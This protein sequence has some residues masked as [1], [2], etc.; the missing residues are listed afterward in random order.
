V[1]DMALL[2]QC[3]PHVSPQTM[4]AII[5]T[6]SGFNPLALHVNGSL[7]LSS[8]PHTAAEAAAWAKWL[9]GQGYSVDLGLM[10]VN[11]NN[12]GRLGMTEADAFDPCQN[13]QAGARILTENYAK[14]A[15]T[16]GLGTN[17]LLQAISAYNTGNFRD[18]FRNGYVARVVANSVPSRAVPVRDIQPEDRGQ[19]PACW[20]DSC[21]TVNAH[22]VAAWAV[23]IGGSVITGFTAY[24]LGVH[25]R[26]WEGIRARVPVLHGILAQAFR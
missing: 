12:L 23:A 22:K 19:I 24:F 5:R 25:R 20:L 11:S 26:A 16:G 10:Q 17:A 8:A 2:H 3:A 14:A 1:L 15:Q 9:I 18:G 13:I 6:E 21:I 4:E 7:R